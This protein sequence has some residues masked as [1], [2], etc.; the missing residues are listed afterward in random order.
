VTGLT[1]T[2][3]VLRRY[4]LDRVGQVTAGYP[5]QFWFLLWG[6][7]VN[8]VGSFMVWPFMSIYL[9]QRLELSLTS[10]TLL[11]TLHSV[12]G[13]GATTITGLAVD[14]F[15]RKGAMT[16]G[17]V[18][19]G[20][21]LVAMSM[22]D[23]LLL[24]VVLM[25]VKGAFTPLYRVGCNSMV[26]DLISPDRRAEAFAFLR[27][28]LNLGVVIGPSAGGF[29]TTVS[30]NLTF[31]IAAGTSVFFALLIQFLVAETVPRGREKSGP[32][33]SDGGYGRI[34]RDGPFQMFC[35][36]Y[37][38]AVMT[39][40]LM[41]ILLPVYAKENFSVQESQYGFIAATNAA[42]VVLFQYLVTRVT[43]R[44]NQL[45]VLA[46]GSLFY[47]LGAASVAWAWNFPTFLLSMVIATIGELIVVPTSTALT[48]NL[49]PPFMRGRYMSFYSLTWQIGFGVG[50]VVG[51]FLNDN[52]APVT[53]W[54]G[55]LTMGLAA[56]LGF[57][58]L[59]KRLR[60]Q[61][62][63]SLTET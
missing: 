40:S 53:I 63:S 17:L 14:R 44:H 42:M 31:Y 46:I 2:F 21:T 52:V 57:A 1:N 55:G 39:Y 20:A 37:S 15:G 6:T 62:L 10:V 30:Y 5:R 11:L 12:A 23:A 24:W 56:T 38:L 43:E 25:A 59:S 35:G 13:L 51:G 29:I 8:A 54:Y 28:V 34:L 19:V 32:S 18:T 4:L 22:V 36:V 60:G 41:M 45:R 49:A 50:P 58:V 7:L 27:M 33:P 3:A 26:A 61:E 16:L 47:A 48:A 9:R